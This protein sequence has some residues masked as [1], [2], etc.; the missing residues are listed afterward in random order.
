VSIALIKALLIDLDNT[1]ML[2]N[3]D[4]FL[5]T[6][7]RLAASYFSDLLDESSFF[8][9][10]LASTLKMLKNDGTVLN[11]EAFTQFFITD[12]PELSF[13]QC[14]QRFKQFYSETFHQLSKIIHPVPY[15]RQLLEHVITVG[16]RVV[17]ATNP[18]FPQV[19]SIQRL[20]WANISDLDFALITHAENMRYCK[21]RPEY[22]L[23]I[24][25]KLSL[26]P[27]VCLMAGND[28]VS[29]MAASSLGIQTFLVDLD[30]EKGR[31]GMISRQLGR[32]KEDFDPAE[33][34]IN[35]QGSLEDLERFIF[36]Q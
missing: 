15:A 8:Q 3:E 17:V 34:T 7:G 16:I 24:L 1:L 28:P 32:Y 12:L 5:T 22:Y 35:G 20:K 23:D 10:L 14:I 27:E 18:I 6:Y 11:Y 21:P 36:N 33:Y 26:Q 29:D 4:E 13:N 25:N 31:L 19:A 30:Q 9:K 2:F